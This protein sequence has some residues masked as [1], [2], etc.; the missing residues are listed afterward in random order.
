MLLC[1]D[2]GNTQI[3]AGVWEEDEIRLRFRYNCRRGDSSD[4]N[5]FSKLLR[6][7]KI[8][9]ITTS[10]PY[11]L[12]IKY[13]KYDDK[14]E[15]KEYIEMI[16]KV[17]QNSKDFLRKGRFVCIN[18]GRE[19]GPINMPAKYDSLMEEI[20][21]VFFRNIYWTKPLGAARSTITSRYPFPRYYV[22]K[23]QTELIEI[24]SNEE[25]PS[26]FDT[27]IT[28]KIG[29]GEKRRDEQIPKILLDKFA[30]NVWDMM[31][32]TTLG[33]DHPAPFPVQLPYNCIRFFSFEGESVVDPFMGS[34]TTMIA[35]DQIKRKFYGIELDPEYV[36]LAI[37]RYLLYNPSAKLK[38]MHKETENEKKEK[39]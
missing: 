14:Q 22:P 36:S 33:K 6:D 1:L 15:Y 28:Y 30:G 25:K 24:Y 21:Y 32:E 38:I 23:V 7:N 9:L 5:T 34:G 37:E 29:E 3:F 17:F 10:P 31:T 26:F 35:A 18:I 39:K 20:G 11:N 8:D 19:W 16:R 27:M 13:G 4:Q 12:D 2:V